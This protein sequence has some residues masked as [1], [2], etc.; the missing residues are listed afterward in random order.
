MTNYRLAFAFADPNT[1][2]LQVPLGDISS[3]NT[4]SND[5][6]SASSNRSKP[7]AH[8]P[9]ATAASASSTPSPTT[10]VI[11]T[12]KSSAFTIHL[13]PPHASDAQRA[14]AALVTYAFPGKQGL[15]Y[16]FAFECK[17]G[18][19]FFANHAA[20]NHTADA[21]D[22][23][24][25]L[26]PFDAQAEF[27][28]QG[29]LQP[30]TVVLASGGGSRSPSP[31]RLSTVNSSYSLCGSY[32]RTL[33]VPAKFSDEDLMAV[34][35]FR[36]EG[37]IPVLTW[38]NKHDSG[39]IW[40][41]AQ[42]H[43]G[44]SGTQSA[45]DELLVKM[46]G[47]AVGVGHG[48]HM[49]PPEY[50]Y[51]MSGDHSFQESINHNGAALRIFDLRPKSAAVANRATGGGYES[52]QGY[53]NAALSFYNIENIHA[54]RNSL[55]K[56]MSACLNPTLNELS[57]SKE[58]DNSQWLHHVKG[59]LS[60][61]WQLAFIVS[62]KKIPTL[63]HCSHG[64]DRTSQVCALSQIFL[65]PFYRTIDG[66]KILVEKDFLGFGHPFQLRCAHG[67]SE[68]E[69]N[70]DQMAPIFLQFLDAVYQ[71]INVFPT[72]FEYNSRYLMLVAKHIYSCRYGTFL[73]NNE[74]ERVASQVEDRSLS[75]WDHLNA[76]RK[77][78]TQ[79]FYRPAHLS[80][81]LA[82]PKLNDASENL[83]LPPLSTILRKVTLWQDYYLMN[84]PKASF[85]QVP[86][87]L[88]P[89]VFQGAGAGPAVRGGRLSEDSE[90][91]VSDL[92]SETSP[93]G[94]GGEAHIDPDVLAVTRCKDDLVEGWFN[95]CAATIAE[96]HAVISRQKMQKTLARELSMSTRAE[97][98]ASV[99][100]DDD[101][102]EGGGRR[103]RRGG[104]SR[105]VRMQRSRG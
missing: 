101:G 16:L 60:A 25:P 95:A 84:S 100:L 27:E 105:G 90:E 69:R 71:L 61:S 79:P 83:F 10:T 87:Y 46:I 38:G 70:K 14:Y 58:V 47:A 41:S 12:C 97:Q 51:N 1:P 64:W 55:S 23:P 24:P 78:L 77:Y 32:P 91:R 17:K 89:Y 67:E 68:Q 88:K 18:G 43:V 65:D 66:F 45:K 28:R 36:S 30:R 20:K 33:C 59:V 56:L 19:D 6:D 5:N 74:R 3:V 21:T 31:Y 35:P 9:G 82:Y 86:R 81:V 92:S 39:S 54:M 103:G 44:L 102:E 62:H 48:H 94:V 26:Q 11:V 53:P 80:S 57:F 8:Y 76:N 29:L 72:H 42:P 37:R 7:T 104:R 63:V 52:T 49:Y 2:R 75:L 22:K 34:K 93:E 73:C 98:S 4:E 13:T 15:D 50:I 96:L 99:F 85:T 40:R